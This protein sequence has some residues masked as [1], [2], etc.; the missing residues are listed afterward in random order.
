MSEASSGSGPFDNDP[1]TP[2]C[3]PACPACGSADT[4]ELSYGAGA[5]GIGHDVIFGD[6]PRWWCRSC[7]RGWG[8]LDDSNEAR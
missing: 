7:Q 1:R 4:Q 2:P 8:R 3:G 5:D 6:E